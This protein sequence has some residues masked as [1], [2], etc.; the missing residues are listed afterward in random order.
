MTLQIV[1]EIL[2]L[3]NAI[4]QMPKDEFTNSKVAHVSEREY[5]AL[6]FKGKPRHF[7]GAGKSLS[8]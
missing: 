7:W 8:S 5:I 3:G 6:N 4:I 1:S 2:S